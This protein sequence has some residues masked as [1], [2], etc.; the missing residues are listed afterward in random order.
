MKLQSNDIQ[1]GARI[2]TRF[3]F[4]QRGPDGR[5]APSDNTSPHLSWSGVPEGTQSFVLSVWDPDVPSSGEDVNQDGRTVPYD[6]PR[7]PFTHLILVDLPASTTELAQGA[8]SQGI[9]AGGKASESAP[10]GR[11]GENDY[12][13][14]FA[15]DADMG[16]TYTSYD[17]P[18]PPWNDERLH[19][20]HFEVFALD[21]ARLA[22][23]GVFTR[24][25]AMAAMD[26]HVLG[27]ARITGTYALKADAR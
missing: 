4:G 6:L 5:F 16:G 26:G 2:D 24:D 22:V 18:C 11:A 9:T 25:A 7:V 27:T 1:D 14:W 19:R 20:Y 10:V 17:G 3:A 8:L 12:T 13:A 15:G 23:E 21:C